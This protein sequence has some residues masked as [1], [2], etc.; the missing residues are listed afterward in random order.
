MN[1]N[2]SIKKKLNKN[3]DQRRPIRIK[4]CDL[5]PQKRGLY[6]PLDHQSLINWPLMKGYFWRLGRGLSRLGVVSLVLSP[7]RMTVN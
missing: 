1:E 6:T 4:F 2:A 7:S 3:G 5:F